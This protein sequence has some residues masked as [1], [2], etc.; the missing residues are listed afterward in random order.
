MRILSI[1]FSLEVIMTWPVN[2]LFGEDKVQL[3]EYRKEL[4]RLCEEEK[5]AEF[6]CRLLGWGAKKNTGT[7]DEEKVTVRVA[8]QHGDGLVNMIA[9]NS[10]LGRGVA[11]AMRLVGKLT[12]RG[13]LKVAVSTPL[14]IVEV[15]AKEMLRKIVDRKRLVQYEIELL[16]RK[17]YPDLKPRV[18]VPDDLVSN[19]S[20]S[21]E[22]W[23]PYPRR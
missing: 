12:D 22:S 14:S 8:D 6:R 5:I 13:S 2:K 23:T 1:G 20:S 10:A 11:F 19:D 16:E 9:G 7:P 21:S 4:A 3:L 17:L 15:G 18:S